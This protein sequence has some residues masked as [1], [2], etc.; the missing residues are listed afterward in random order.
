MLSRI[1]VLVVLF[2]IFGLAFFGYFDFQAP[3]RTQASG[4]LV[5]SGVSPSNGQFYLKV[6]NFPRCYF[7]DSDLPEAQRE[8]V[9]F[10]ESTASTLILSGEQ[11]GMV[12][13]KCKIEGWE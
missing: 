4:P 7:M 5:G 2:M 1:V 12:L 6:E 10:K 8:M 3:A 13:D 11:S 9:K